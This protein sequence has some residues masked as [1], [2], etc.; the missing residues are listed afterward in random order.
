MVVTK[1]YGTSWVVGNL[2]VVF[3]AYFFRDVFQ[4][5]LVIVCPIILTLIPVFLAKESPRWLISK[6]YIAQA[7][8]QIKS[9]ASDNG[10][11]VNPDLLTPRKDNFMVEDAKAEDTTSFKDLFTPN[12]ICLRTLILFMQVK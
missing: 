4:L 9:M 2:L 12:A 5:Q 7:T 11:T 6:G 10:K 3:W 8:A 1:V